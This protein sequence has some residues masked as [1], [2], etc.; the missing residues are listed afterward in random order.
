[1]I[2]INPRF[3]LQARSIFREQMSK[4]MQDTAIVTTERYQEVICDLYIE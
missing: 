4:M 3:A 2:L 1:M